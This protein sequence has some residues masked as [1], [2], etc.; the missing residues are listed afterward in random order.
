MHCDTP[1]FIEQPPNDHQTKTHHSSADEAGT[2]ESVKAASEI[3]SPV[4]GTV[5]ETN[6]KLEQQPGLV[7][8]S[9][10]EDGWIYKLELKN[11]QELSELMK[12]EAYEEYLRTIKE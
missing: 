12:K 2:I 7:N 11:K 10:Y 5:T 1:D 4:S 8:K 6:P 9:C 3:Y